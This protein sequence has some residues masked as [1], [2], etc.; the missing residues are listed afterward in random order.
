MH[1]SRQ[2]AVAVAERLGPQPDS[3]VAQLGDAGR[4]RIALWLPALNFVW[5][6][7][8]LPWYGNLS[9]LAVVL[10]YGSFPVFFV[11]C[12]QT[13]FGSSAHAGAWAGALAVLSLV[14]I[15][16]SGSWSYV[17]YVAAL[18]PFCSR[19]WRSLGWVTLLLFAYV[20]VATTIAGYPPS[21]TLICI[22]P[23]SCMVLLSMLIRATFE[24]D[25][26]LRRSQDEVRRLA[27]V[28]ERERIGRDL[29]DLL[30]HTLS[31]VAVKSQLARRLV[32]S[33][34]LAA[35]RQLAEIEQVA[36]ASLLQVREAV[37]GMRAAAFVA[38]LASARLMFEAGDIRYEVQVADLDLTTRIE[39][40]LALAFREAVTNVQRHSRATRVE[41]SLQ[42]GSGMAELSV[43][44]NG[45]G[46]V[47]VKGNGLKGMEERLAAVGGSLELESPPGNGTLLRIR[48]PLHEAAAA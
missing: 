34:A 5:L 1:E 3:L 16:I 14:M 38:E 8:M 6:F 46:G 39:S 37:T 40:A 11:L 22:V 12:R 48:V 9:S 15:P 41:V 35:E 28:A 13:W 43:R 44:D 20:V 10:T 45:R 29:H 2:W 36:R 19:G 32:A 25:T 47:Q 27:V 7:W 42:H 17:L 31:L 30:G 24:S 23:T 26:A 4:R 33:D 21:T 18:I